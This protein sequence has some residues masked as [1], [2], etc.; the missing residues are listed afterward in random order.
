MDETETGLKGFIY[1]MSVV[2]LELLGP[3]Y[4]EKV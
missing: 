1:Q 2:V 3:L 4:V